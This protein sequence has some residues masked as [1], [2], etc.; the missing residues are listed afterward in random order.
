MKSARALE[1]VA[2]LALGAVASPFALAADPVLYPVWYLGGSV[3]QSRSH[4]NEAGIAAVM[5]GPG[6]ATA[7]IASDDR[8]VGYKL[9]AGYQFNRNFALEGG[10]FNLGEHS[11]TTTTVPAGSLAGTIKVR[12]VNLD[13]V[14]ILPLSEHF[15]VFGRVGATYAKTRDEFFRTGA[16]VVGNPTPEESDPGYKFGLGIQIDFNRHLGVRAEAERYRV[17]DGVGGRAN[18]D[19]YSIGLVWR[20]AKAPAPPPPVQRAP[21]PVTPAPPPPPAV[22]PAPPAPVVTPPPAPPPAPVDKPIRKDRN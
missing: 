8:D 17:S 2:L 19:L 6:V 4:Y 7:S 10:Y 3:G 16:V 14:G 11:F 12:G 13:A 18:V 1:A 21:E 15:S 20:F 9:F 5:Q 22:K